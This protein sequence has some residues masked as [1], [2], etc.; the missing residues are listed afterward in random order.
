M[1]ESVY[2]PLDRE[3][4]DSPIGVSPRRWQQYFYL[5]LAFYALSVAVLVLEPFQQRGSAGITIFPEFSKHQVTFRENVTFERDIPGINNSVWNSLL[6][7]GAGFIKVDEPTR[8]GLS[9]GFPLE[10]LPGTAEQYCISMFHQLNCLATLKRAFEIVK[11]S[12]RSSEPDLLLE[13]AAHCW[14]YLRQ[15]IM[16]AA[17]LTLETAIVKDGK[18]LSSVDGWDSTH[19]C[20]DYGEVYAYAYEHRSNHNQDGIINEGENR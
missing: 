9:G 19:Q 6:P 1:S 10:D 14:D 15:A 4:E 20:I 3:V 16:C 7:E 18:M 13:H 2:A 11:Q 12:P 8:F 17:D 5:L